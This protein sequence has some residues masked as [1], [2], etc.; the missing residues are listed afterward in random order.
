M[1]L[2]ERNGDYEEEHESK[3]IFG[4]MFKNM[5][6]FGFISDWLVYIALALSLFNFFRR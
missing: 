5:S 1:E 4:E 6:V 2:E 3:S